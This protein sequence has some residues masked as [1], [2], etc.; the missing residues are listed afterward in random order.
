[1][2]DEQLHQRVTN[3]AQPSAGRVLWLT[4]GLG[5]GGTERLLAGAVAHLD[6]ARHHVEIAYLLPH[7]D[8]LVAEIEAHDICV[9]CLGAGAALDLRWVGALRR[10]VAERHFDIVHTH[11]PHPALGARLALGHGNGPLIVHTEH[12]V[13]PRYRAV[14]RW[15][16][17]MTYHRNS[18]VLAVS[19]GVA[20]SVRPPR[21]LRR[22]AP[23]VEVLVHGIDLST[24]RR[25][26]ATRAR[27]RA[28]LGFDD[29]ELVVGTVGNLT[30][31]KDHRTLLAAVELLAASEPRVRLV[32][33]GSGPLD[34]EVRAEAAR[35]GLADRVVFTGSRE[36][37]AELLT[38]FDVYA[39]SSRYEGLSIA[40]LEAMATGLP[41][42]VTRVGG[43][44]EVVTD[45]VEGWLVEPGD[46]PAL[47]EALR[48]LVTDPRRRVAMG[49]RAARRAEPFELAGAVR[50]T[51]AVYDEVLHR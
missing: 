39:L 50:R 29:D 37:V 48:R 11:G 19:Q 14:T 32:V 46:P 27:T 34:G 45:G 44:P 20:D 3:Q 9:H 16:N 43:N 38:A 10:L 22:S 13:W 51:Q 26:P 42:V 28:A 2:I 40:L 6:R 25:D 7:K 4:K 12:N 18:R 47:A 49:E 5:R 41:C 23:P 31:K 30:A 15:A 8:A 24:V 21:L 17:A 1:M 33:V 35:R 36:D